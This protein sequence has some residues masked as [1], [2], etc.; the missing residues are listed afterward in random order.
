MKRKVLA[1]VIP[2]LLAAGA[3]HAAE[4]YNK[5]GN[6]LDL[7]GKVDGL[8]YFSDN[9]GSDGDQTYV[10]FGFKGE[11]QINDQLTGYGQW[12]Y[13]VQANTTEGEGANSWTRLAFAGLK[14]GDYGSFDYGRNYGVLYDVEGWTDML[15][16]F[17]GDSYTYADN[18]M[19]GRANGVATYRNTD[20]FGLVDGLS[21]ALQ[22]QGNNENSGNGNEGTNNRTDDDDFRRENGDGFGISTTYDFGM[23]FSAGAAYTTSDRTN[24]QVS[25]GEQYAK[26][27]K[28]DAWTAG[29]KYD[30]NNIYL[31]TMYSET[32]NMTPYGS[33]DSDAHGGVANKTQNFEVTAQYQFDFGLRPAISF[34]M[35]KGKDLVNNGVNDDKD[36]VKY[37]DVGATYYFNKNFSTYVDYKI[38]LLDD[39]D[40]FYADNGINTDDVVA[41]GMVYQF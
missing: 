18:Y 28:A 30:A 11:T 14:F 23:G 38:N 5:D 3:A 16:E 35:S 24:D 33:L 34:L 29:L 25:R 27:D 4:V 32:R 40:N 13:N 19:T 2:A 41:L 1:L 21:F 17:G 31:A 10:R 6:K 9:S 22:Y 26:G 20:F 8:H 7:Y 15:P 36:L 37:A 39:D 12:E